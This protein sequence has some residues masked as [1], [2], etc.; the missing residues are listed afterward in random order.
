[1]DFSFDRDRFTAVDVDAGGGADRIIVSRVGG[2]FVDE[3][4]T[5]DGGSGDDVLIGGDANEVLVGGSGNDS[6]DGNIGADRAFLGSGADTFTWNI[7]DGS[8]TVEGDSGADLLAFDGS[9]APELIGVTANGSR[10]RLTRNIGNVTMDLDSLE[11]ARVRTFG[12]ADTVTVGDLTHTD[13][14]LVDIDG[15][16][17]A[18]APDGAVDNVLVDGTAGADRVA[19]SSPLPGTALV[20]GLAAAVQLSGADATLDQITVNGLAGADSLT[21]SVRVTGPSAILFNGGDQGDAARY[22]GTENGDVIGVASLGGPVT[23][24]TPNTTR[25]DA[26]GVEDV[27]VDGLDGNDVIRTLGDVAARTRLTLDG[28]DDDDVLVGGDGADALF[29]GDGDDR[30]DGNLG[31]DDADLGRG[32]DVFVWDPGDGSD[33]VDGQSGDDRMDF[34][35]SNVAEQMRVFRNGSRSRLTRDVGAITMDFDRL[36]AVAI[37]AQAAPTT[38]PSA[39]CAGPASAT[40]QSNSPRSPSQGD[41]AADVVTVEGTDRRDT[42]DVTRAGDAGA[43]RRSRRQHA[44]HGLRADARR[45]ADQR[46]GR[47]RRRAASRRTSSDLIRTVVDLGPE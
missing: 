44:D 14:D 13:L 40:S 47:R 24:F 4:I 17:S 8:D 27:A 46:P 30:V 16:S 45:A 12:E 21:S 10:A 22:S 35:G 33:V 9:N 20:S 41:A 3:A 6:V 32:D 15:L 29:G 25:L 43:R 31:A 26:I 23:A 42:I 18:Q 37:R 19:V 11:T 38:S 2:F 1:M 7:G 34:N 39:T 36:E 5:L 28:G